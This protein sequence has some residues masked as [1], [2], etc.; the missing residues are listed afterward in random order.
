MTS[1]SSRPPDPTVKP[2]FY[3]VYIENPLEQEIEDHVEKWFIQVDARGRGKEYNY[4]GRIT[5]K[6]S[7]ENSASQAVE[8][9]QWDD[10][11]HVEYLGHVEI[12]DVFGPSTEAPSEE[13]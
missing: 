11:L 8:D 2:G 9:A 3:R 4:L 13:N 7:K 6:F 5:H 12:W 1:H 10:R